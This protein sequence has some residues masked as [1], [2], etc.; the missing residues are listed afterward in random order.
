M[1]HKADWNLSKDLVIAKKDAG[2][3]LMPFDALIQIRLVLWHRQICASK[4]IG[5]AAAANAV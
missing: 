5:V 2:P 3:F 1:I 4:R